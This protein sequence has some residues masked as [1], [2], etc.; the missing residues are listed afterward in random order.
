MLFVSFVLKSYFHFECEFFGGGHGMEDLKDHDS[1]D[2]GVSNSVAEAVARYELDVPAEALPN[3]EK[4]CRLLWD[5]NS[6]LNLTRHTDYDKFVTR[7]V[8]DSLQLAQLLGQGERI[9]DVGSGGGVPGLLLAILRPDLDVS[10]SESIGKK[11]VA[12]RAMAD[13]LNLPVAIHGCRAED[14]LVDASFE[15]LTARAVGPLWKMLKLFQPRWRS[16]GCIFLIKGPRWIEE[17]GEA[18]HRGLLRDIELRRVADY[19]TPDTDAQNVIL[20]LWRTG[21]PAG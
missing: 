9:L 11:A 20:K 21:R 8:V 7:D 12:L 3:L 5:W 17:R 2:R 10:L 18:R 6:K 19:K 16:I 1:P 4:Y 14:L 15:V 13:A